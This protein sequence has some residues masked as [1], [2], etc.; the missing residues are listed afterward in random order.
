LILEVTV[1]KKNFII[2]NL[3]ILVLILAILLI[4]GDRGR[5]QIIYPL[6]GK[7]YVVAND[8]NYSYESLRVNKLELYTPYSTLDADKQMFHFHSGDKF[9]ID[10]QIQTGHADFGINYVYELRADEFSKLTEYIDSN[11]EQIKAHATKNHYGNIY[12]E[13][14]KLY[15]KDKNKFYVDEYDLMEFLKS[16][17]IVYSS[18]RFENGFTYLSFYIFVY[19]VITAFFFLLL[20]YRNKVMF[21][22][23]YS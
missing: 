12:V 15:Y 19:P 4:V 9:H 11:F 7:T 18:N 6:V 23:K 10:R 8:T 20:T 5:L 2:K 21:Y 16:Q 22:E 1:V 17:G 3:H 13:K 14:S